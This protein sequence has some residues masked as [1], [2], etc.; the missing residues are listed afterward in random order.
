MAQA[1]LDA[2]ALETW[3]EQQQAVRQGPGEETFNM[4]LIATDSSES[5]ERNF[6]NNIS[7]VC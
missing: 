6:Q 7:S 2:T 3:L 5:H 1:V 4:F